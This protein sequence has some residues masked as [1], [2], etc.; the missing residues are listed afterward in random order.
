MKKTILFFL[1]LG[2]ITLSSYTV[3][4]FYVSVTQIEH[5]KEQQTLQIIS[6]IFIDDIEDLLKTRYDESL[7]IDTTKD[8]PKLDEYLKK[9]LDQK[10]KIKV[11]DKD[12]AFNFLGK[13]YEDDLMICYLEVQNISSLEEINI[14]NEV[15]M[16][17]FEEQ[18]N[19]VH[20]KKENQ[21]KSLILEKGKSEGLLNFSE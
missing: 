9:Y 11:N 20:V 3:H 17:V 5:N 13:E 16:D 18:Q 4:K 19:I 6:R 14:S 1:I 21:R 15:L 2:S 12:I 10:I 7:T 8:D